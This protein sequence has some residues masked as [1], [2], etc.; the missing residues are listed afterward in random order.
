MVRE[1]RREAA[2]EPPAPLDQPWERGVIN[3][4]IRKTGATAP[5]PETRSGV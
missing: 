2:Q 1:R 5:T 4:L 3:V